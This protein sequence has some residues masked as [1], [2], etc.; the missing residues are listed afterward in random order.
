MVAAGAEVSRSYGGNVQADAQRGSRSTLR[1]SVDVWIHTRFDERFG[2]RMAFLRQRDWRR[3]DGD[4]SQLWEQLYELTDSGMRLEIQG[5]DLL[6]G[7]VSGNSFSAAGRANSLDLRAYGGGIQLESFFKICRQRR[8]FRPSRLFSGGRSMT[9]FGSSA[10]LGAG[11]LPV[12]VSETPSAIPLVSQIRFL[13]RDCRY[14]PTVFNGLLHLGTSVLGGGGLLE[15]GIL[16][17]SAISL[18]ARWLGSGLGSN[19]YG[20]G[21][22][23]GVGF[24]YSP[25]GFGIGF[26]FAPAPVWPF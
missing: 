26:G 17:G 5:M 6:A 18:A 15:G 23:A 1:L 3:E 4:V 20:Q 14:S 21:D 10:A 24:G 19:V 22:S 11:I 13:D 8:G 16:A 25:G 9:N 12:S 2:P 7:N